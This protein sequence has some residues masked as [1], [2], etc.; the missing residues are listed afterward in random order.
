MIP[1]E[2]ALLHYLHTILPPFRLNAVPR[3]SHRRDPLDI[4]ATS[5]LPPN[6]SQVRS[7]VNP[8]DNSQRASLNH[9]RLLRLHVNIHAT[10]KTQTSLLIMRCCLSSMYILRRVKRCASMVL[11]VA[12]DAPCI[13][14]QRNAAAGAPKSNSSYK[15]DEDFD[16]PFHRLR[17]PIH[18]NHPLQQPRT[19]ENMEAAYYLSASSFTNIV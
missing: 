17:T 4:S 5:Y 12:R 13:N 9:L 19:V 2:L 8:E 18:S 3:N 11:I 6:L 16:S 14:P 1:Q 10:C 7:G 15:V